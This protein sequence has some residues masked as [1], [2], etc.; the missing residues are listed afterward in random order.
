[1]NQMNATELIRMLTETT[2]LDEQASIVH[3]LY[4]KLYVFFTLG[5]LKT[6]YFSEA[7]N[8]ILV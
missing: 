8:M 7:S 5:H 2:L 1:M 3:F 6:R 4:L